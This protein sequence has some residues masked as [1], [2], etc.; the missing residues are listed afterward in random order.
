MSS[1]TPSQIRDSIIEK[2]H[3]YILNTKRYVSLP[4]AKTWK[5]L[6][7]LEEDID[8]LRILLYKAERLSFKNVTTPIGY[9]SDVIQQ[10]PEEYSNGE[11]IYY[12][13]REGLPGLFE[14]PIE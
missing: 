9:Q 5:T 12:Q 2:T 13:E 1:L 10:L 4:S 6:Q 7:N 3:Q 14:F 11:E 8:A